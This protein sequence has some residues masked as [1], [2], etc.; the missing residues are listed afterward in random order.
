M[1]TIQRVNGRRHLERGRR[2]RVLLATASRDALAGL[3]SFAAP[4]ERLEAFSTGG[5]YSQLRGVNLVVADVPALAETDGIGRDGLI[6]VM[7]QSGIAWCQPAEFIADPRAWEAQAL[8]AIGAIDALPPKAIAFA[9][10]SGGVGKTT[11][12]LDLARFF[13]GPAVKLPAA[14]VELR[15]GKSSLRALLDRDA[16]HVYE[17]CTQDLAPH[18]WHGVTLVPMEYETAQLLLGRAEVLADYFRRLKAAHVLTIFDL[19]PDNA[20]ADGVLPLLDEIYGMAAPRA[21]AIE[22]A[23]QA[24]ADLLGRASGEGHP[25]NGTSPRLRTGLI[26]NQHRGVTDRVA[27]AGVERLTELPW[28]DGAARYDGQLGRHLVRVVYPGWRP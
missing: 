27:L 15:H 22:N 3:G 14:V 20:F 18:T 5:V 13:A 24:V 4:V 12:S 1:T 28:L 2:L 16:P 23:Q 10:Y 19:E 17:I 6:G 25:K 11:C 26:I 7:R 8:S 9:S 21:D